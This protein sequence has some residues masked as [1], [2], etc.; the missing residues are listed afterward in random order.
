MGRQGDGVGVGDISPFTDGGQ[1]IQPLK[2]SFYNVL[3]GSSVVSAEG[4]LPQVQGP[5]VGGLV[6]LTLLL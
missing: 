2:G 1:A 5:R 3:W 4:A 6:L